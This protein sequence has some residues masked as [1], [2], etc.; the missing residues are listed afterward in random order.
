MLGCFVS[1]KFCLTRHVFV[2][3]I[4]V[5]FLAPQ[6]GFAHTGEPKGESSPQRQYQMLKFAIQEYGEGV[7]GGV[8]IDERE[9][10]TAEET[11]ANLE[12]EAPSEQLT[13]LRK[14]VAERADVAKLEAVFGEWLEEHGAGIVSD[15]PERTPSIAAGKNLFARYCVSCHGDKG[16]G[17][18]PL[19]DE[20]EGPK[21]VAFT[22]E[23]FMVNETPEE[24]F[25]VLTLGVPGSV[26]PSWEEVLTAQERWDMVAFLWSLA[27]PPANRAEMN[28]CTSCHTQERATAVFSISDSDLIA[29]L[30]EIEAHRANADSTARL[31]RQLAFVESRE[32]D[33]LAQAFD[34]HHLLLSVDLLRE[35]YS[36]AV[37]GGI[38]VDAIE[39]GESRLFFGTLQA[40]IDAGFADGKLQDPEIRTLTKAI[41]EMVYAKKEPNEVEMR[42]VEL[43]RALQDDLGLREEAQES[44]IVRV[45]AILDEAQALAVTAPDQAASKILGAYMAF[46]AV[47]KKLIA[48][49]LAF[50]KGIEAQFV[51]LR[52]K[53]SKGGDTSAE[54]TKIRTDLKKAE[55]LLAGKT[56]FLEGFLASILIILRE[57]LEVILVVSALAAYLTKGGHLAERRWLFEGAIVGVVASFL[58]AG[59]FE[60]AFSGTALAKEALEGM[61]MLV[62]AVVL[63]FVS[64]WLLSKVG[65]QHWQAYIHK[66]LNHA[67][68][69]GSRFAMSF[70]AFLAVYREGFETVLFYR[71]LMVSEG[72]KSAVIVGFLL[73]CV[74]LIGLWIAVMRFSMKIP[75]R[76]FF[77]G[78]GVFLYA[79]ALRFVGGG[80]LELQEAG[81]VHSTPVSWWPEFSLLS[82]APNLET[83]LAQ[84]V[85][86]LAALVAFAVIFLQRVTEKSSS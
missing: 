61:T 42:L 13:E 69:S 38:V 68:G 77:A 39:Y 84:L 19:A 12:K 56:N 33:A 36:Q 46:E 59:I 27:G 5:L 24:F 51:E 83:G 11:L 9:L 1:N 45:L 32:G 80:I 55:A 60:F 47:E 20:I 75:L 29:R 63:F 78:T 37:K 18:G 73:G 6:T 31:A 4:F 25:Q 2:S 30:T 7:Q 41:G 26:M 3:L 14:L 53:V 49:D 54:F 28:N 82:M 43:R 34:Q 8:V 74:V 71:A 64:Y 52:S 10:A 22:D 85:L 44:V 40:D 21:P 48:L 81:W 15:K 86:I 35:E 58:T 50:G 76:P 17:K 72:S 62:A 79:L 65:A 57:G 16:D 67:L 66:Q 23:S 70:A